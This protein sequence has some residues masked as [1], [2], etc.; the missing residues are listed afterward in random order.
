MG[1]WNP[2]II[3]GRNGKTKKIARGNLHESQTTGKFKPEGFTQTQET[4]TKPMHSPKAQIHQYFRSGWN[5][6]SP[7]I[8]WE[9]DHFERTSYQQMF[10]LIKTS[11][12]DVQ[13]EKSWK[14]ISV[15]L[16]EAQITA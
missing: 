4:T 2:N 6:I 14:V 11:R 16:A 12:R 9:P 5:A 7:L 10:E 15:L 3:T 1:Y 8:I 13:A